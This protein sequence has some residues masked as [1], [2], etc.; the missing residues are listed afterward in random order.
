MFNGERVCDWKLKFAAKLFANFGRPCP[1][2]NRL[3][4]LTLSRKLA[5]WVKQCQLFDNFSLVTKID[6]MYQTSENRPRHHQDKKKKSV[7]M[8]TIILEQLH[9]TILRERGKGTCTV[10][11]RILLADN[12]NQKKKKKK[13]T[14]GSPQRYLIWSSKWKKLVNKKSFKK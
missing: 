13:K 9:I 10:R 4:D 1:K 12:Y 3:F 6:T 8:D 14:A 5:Y 11:Q 2:L 7:A